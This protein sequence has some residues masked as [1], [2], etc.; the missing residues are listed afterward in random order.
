[1]RE[2]A[3]IYAR[4][5]TDMQRGNYSIPSQV[6][7]CLHYV[8]KHRYLLIGNQFVDAETGL[9][10]KKQTNSIAAYVDNY[11][12]SETSRPGFDAVLAYLDAAG[13]EVLVIHALDRFDL[14]V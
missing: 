4:V 5:S 2:R 8:K 6:A 12:S 14:S 9:D 3:V 13:F 7:E 10:V 11:T 1:M